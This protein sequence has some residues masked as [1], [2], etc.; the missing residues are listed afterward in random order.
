MSAKRISFPFFVFFFALFL[1]LS[2]YISSDSSVSLFVFHNWNVFWIPISAST[3][4]MFAMPRFR[5]TFLGQQTSLKSWAINK[6]SNE[7][8]DEIEKGHRFHG[9][10]SVNSAKVSLFHPFC[11]CMSAWK[12]SRWPFSSA[13][14]HTVLYRINAALCNAILLAEC[15]LLSQRNVA[16]YYIYICVYCII[17]PEYTLFPPEAKQQL[18]WSRVEVRD[19]FRALVVVA[20]TTTEHNKSSILF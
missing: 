20:T 14:A 12:R 15:K 7:R 17:P 6:I 5:W 2:S 11:V 10:K 13:F 9:I 18:F 4:Q 19:V 3:I 16:R 1:Y 8:E